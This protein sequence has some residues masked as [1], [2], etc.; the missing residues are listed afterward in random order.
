MSSPTAPAGNPDNVGFWSAT[1]DGRLAFCRCLDC[2]RWMHPPLE[3]C[4]YC[5][6]PVGFQPVRPGGVAH[7]FIV[8]HQSAVYGF[9]NEVPYVIALVEFDEP[10]VRFV[11]KFRGQSARGLPASDIAVGLRVEAVIEP[12]AGTDRFYPTVRPEAA[13][14]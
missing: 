6:G 2:E 8:V 3:R 11:A 10:G 1:A 7:S 9:T 5:G 12:V 4:R 13:E 14:D